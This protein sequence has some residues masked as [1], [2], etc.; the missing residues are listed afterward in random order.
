M[1]GDHTRKNTIGLKNSQTALFGFSL[2]LCRI[3]PS[4]SSSLVTIVT[5]LHHLTWLFIRTDS[6]AGLERPGD[7]LTP[8]VL[9]MLWIWARVHLFT[10][11]IT[12]VHIAFTATPWGSYSPH[13]TPDKTFTFITRTFCRLQ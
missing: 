13:R 5:C 10:C 4:V 7:L 3:T 8:G 9:F 1:K 6:R 2:P 12:R 11:D